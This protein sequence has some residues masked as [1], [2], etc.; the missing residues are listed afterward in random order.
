[1]ARNINTRVAARLAVVTSHQLRGELCVRV[2]RAQHTLLPGKR[3]L[4]QGL[5]L[6]RPALLA[7][8]NGEGEATGCVKA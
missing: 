6:R 1:M 5:C 4:Q 7:A 3:V 8:Y 2:P